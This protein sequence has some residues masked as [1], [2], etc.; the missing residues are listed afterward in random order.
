MRMKCPSCGSEGRDGAKFCQECGTPFTRQTAT[1]TLGVP[2]EETTESLNVMR[3]EPLQVH[4]RARQIEAEQVKLLYKQAPAGCVATVLNA[5]IVTAVLWKVV[6]HSLLLTWLGLLIVIILSLFVLLRLY[7]RRT[8]TV[9]RI[10]FWR[11]VFIIGVGCGATVGG[12]AGVLLFPYNS[13]IHQVFLVF[14]LGGMAAGAVA[15][16]SPVMAAFLAVFIP[17]L[18]PIT[19]QLFLQ[20]DAV[21]VP[22]GLLLLSFAGVLLV[23]AHHQQ[24]SITESLRLRFENLDLIHHLSVTKEVELRATIAEAVNQRLEKEI[25]ERK[26]VEEALRYRVKM[27]TLIT[28]LSTSFINLARGEIDRAINDALQAVGEFAGVDRSYLFLAYDNETK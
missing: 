2:P 8:P 12:A 13:L 20:G 7:Q 10:S 11:I 19:V 16:L 22:M 25:V 17:T 5:G 28:A 1:P 24:A 4:Q 27:E 26:Q 9:G 14:V 15:V 23:M 6:A 18:L 21:H 3:S